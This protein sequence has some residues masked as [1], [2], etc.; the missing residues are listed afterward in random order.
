MIIKLTYYGKGTPT[1]VNIDNVETI[2]S[3]ADS[4]RG[5]I[6]TKI[7][8]ASGSYMNVEETPAEIMDIQ[9]NIM[10]GV[11]QDTNFDTPTVKDLL[12]SSF[13]EFKINNERDF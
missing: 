8:F 4:S 2:Y 5:K 6:S 11:L 9:N 10:N 13:N 7:Q 1:L 3:V 12:K